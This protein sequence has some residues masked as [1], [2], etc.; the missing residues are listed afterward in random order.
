MVSPL[1]T[2]SDAHLVASVLE[3]V[4]GIGVVRS[5]TLDH[6]ANKTVDRAIRE[7]ERINVRLKKKLCAMHLPSKS[8][9]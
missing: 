4:Q 1:K 2:E 7:N 3:Y 9:T 6:E 5:Y 8:D